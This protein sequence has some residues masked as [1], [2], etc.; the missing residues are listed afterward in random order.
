MDLKSCNV[1]I[2]GDGTAEISDV[3]LAALIH[4]RYLSQEAP[5]G[6]FAWVAPEGILGGLPANA[7]TA[8]QKGCQGDSVSTQLLR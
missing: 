8:V 1:L 7:L 6:N 3:G 5:A 2:S 4:D